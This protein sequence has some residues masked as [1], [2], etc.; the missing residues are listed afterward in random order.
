MRAH[1][2]SNCVRLPA[3]RP[4]RSTRCNKQGLLPA[5]R[6]MCCY[7][8]QLFSSCVNFRILFSVRNTEAAANSYLLTGSN[9]SQMYSRRPWTG[10]LAQNPRSCW[11]TKK[12]RFWHRTLYVR[13]L[14]PVPQISTSD[15]F[16]I[17]ANP[18]KCPLASS[19][20]TISMADTSFSRVILASLEA[21]SSR[22]AIRLLL[23]IYCC[24]KVYCSCVWSVALRFVRN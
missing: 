3:L 20:P 13:S 9:C 23:Y 16:T 7:D 18:P 22:Y 14:K 10:G 21:G 6:N 15:P 11:N 19:F 8:T 5:C 24:C 4:A 2:G 1:T 12:S 17:S